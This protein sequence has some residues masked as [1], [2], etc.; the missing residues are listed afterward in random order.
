MG[1]QIAWESEF[2]SISFDAAADDPGLI[3]GF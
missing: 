3:V 1:C 2:Y